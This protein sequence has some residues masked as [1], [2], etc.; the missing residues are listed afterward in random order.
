MKWNIGLEKLG[1]S[2]IEK[3]QP[4]SFVRFFVLFFY[5]D[6]WQFNPNKYVFGGQNQ[7]APFGTD[8]TQTMAQ[9]AFQARVVVWHPFTSCTQPFSYSLLLV[10]LLLRDGS[11]VRGHT[12]RSALV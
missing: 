4:V 6:H 12:W 2:P 1:W 11:L 9:H 10:R 8:A 5:P 3:M 7:H